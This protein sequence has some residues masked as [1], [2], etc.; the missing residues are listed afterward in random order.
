M[1]AEQQWYKT[2]GTTAYGYVAGRRKSLPAS[3]GL[4]QS[5]CSHTSLSSG[6]TYS[7]S[8]ISTLLLKYSYFKY[9][10]NG[11]LVMQALE[12]LAFLLTTVLTAKYLFS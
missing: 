8:K 11:I 9:T 1:L 10:R 6:T 3:S 7:A 4:R 2:N 5:S 12:E